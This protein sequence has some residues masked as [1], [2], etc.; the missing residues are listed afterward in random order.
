MVH[1]DLE[2]LRRGTESG[3]EGEVEITV[4]QD[5]RVSQANEEEN[6]RQESSRQLKR[7][8]FA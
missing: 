3:T 1:V 5:G 6:G 4:G 2:G 7:F 8:H